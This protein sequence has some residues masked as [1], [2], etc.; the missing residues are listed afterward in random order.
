MMERCGRM[1]AAGR[2]LRKYGRQGAQNE[3]ALFTR[4][5]GDVQQAWRVCVEG[6][7]AGAAGA[8][9]RSVRTSTRGGGGEGRSVAVARGTSDEEQLRWKGGLAKPEGC[10][11]VGRAGLVRQ[12]PSRRRR[13]ATEAERARPWRLRAGRCPWR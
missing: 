10:R 6:A 12:Q 8:A 5:R 7:A 9:Q 2:G 4:G 3:L 13:L 11:T 1:V